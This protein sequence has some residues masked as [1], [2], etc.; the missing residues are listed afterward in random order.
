M[1]ISFS[2]SFKI[3]IMW[4]VNDKITQ[5]WKTVKKEKLILYIYSLTQ[6]VA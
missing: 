4:L 6:K 5:E 2:R 1:L 3:I